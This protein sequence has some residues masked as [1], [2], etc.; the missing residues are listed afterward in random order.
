M[1]RF[2]E[3]TGEPLDPDC[4]HCHLPPLIDA[5]MTA[6]PEVSVEQVLIQLAQTLGEMIGSAAPDAHCA[7]LAA[8]GIMRYIRTAARKIATA[9]LRGGH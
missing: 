6:H 7:D 5:W 1:T 8:V 2:K 3:L 9:P 4:L